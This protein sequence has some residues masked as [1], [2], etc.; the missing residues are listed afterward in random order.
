MVFSSSI[1]DQCNIQ[2]HWYP[3]SISV[4]NFLVNSGSAIFKNICEFIRKE[5]GVGDLRF[6]FSVYIRIAVD[7]FLFR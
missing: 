4:S 2:T 5:C 6:L 1:D 7:D 3:I